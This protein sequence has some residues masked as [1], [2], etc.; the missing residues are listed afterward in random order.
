[1]NP[2]VMVTNGG[3]HPPELWAETTAARIM[4]LVQIAETAETAEAIAARR[5]KS[6]LIY[7]LYDAFLPA[8]TAVSSDVRNGAIPAVG[9]HAIRMVS[10][11]LSAMQGTAFEAHF[12]QTAVVDAVTKA[13]NDDLATAISIE[14]DWV[15]QA[16]QNGG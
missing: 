7:D 16:S 1:M 5:L 11:V 15:N 8:F 2:I 10:S 9:G 14:H 6:K 13:I 12:N 3:P 4:S